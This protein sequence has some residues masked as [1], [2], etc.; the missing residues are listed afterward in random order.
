MKTT[1]KISTVIC[2]I[3][4]IGNS[5]N[6]LHSRASG[7]A[8]PLNSEISSTKI[9]VALLL[10]A[11]NSMDG[12]I[13]QAKSRLWNIVN[14]MTTL[15]YEG[16]TPQ[17]EIALYMYGNDG[18][19]EK[20]NYIKQLTPFTSDLDVI[21]EKLFTIKTNGGSEYC[22]AVID[23]AVK[24]LDWGREKS[25]MRL[26]YI[27][28]NEPFTQGSV[29]Y[30]EAIADAIKK[31][32]YI[33]TIFCGDYSEGVN[34]S[35]KDGANIGKGQYFNI[36]QQYRIVNIVTPYD[37][38]I[39]RCNERL[40][41]TYIYYGNS[42]MAGY[43]N[44]AAQDMNSMGVSK[45][46]Y[47]ERAVTKSNKLYNNS[48]WDLVDKVAV[49]SLYIEK[50]E[51]NDLPSEYKDLT[52]SELRIL[53]AEKTTERSEIQKQISSLAVRRQ[54]YID[55]QSKTDDSELDD[56]G[57]AI[58]VSILDIALSKGFSTEN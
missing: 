10:D 25:D 38:E 50:V 26:I 3:I 30:K 51:M 17:I 9:Q 7:I 16:K 53:V 23:E 44:Q 56:L 49:D 22:G 39:Q 52:H 36:N 35:W 28:G 5:F 13:D 24:R 54:E 40:N 48:G 6:T 57:K 4:F 20:S 12:L 14:T 41:K 42:G 32:I 58:N 31:D 34:T 2:L 11:S 29:S 21:S 33:H 47:T 46:N 27:A 37:D 55:N 8:I 15:R 43:Q 1:F 18:I 19:S 45:S